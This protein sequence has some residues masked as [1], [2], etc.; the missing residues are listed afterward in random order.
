[1]TNILYYFYS[2]RSFQFATGAFLKR[3]AMEINCG[4]SL[5][6][7][8]CYWEAQY[9][10]GAAGRPDWPRPWLSSGLAGGAAGDTNGSRGG[11]ASAPVVN[12]SSSSK[13]V[14]NQ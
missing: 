8:V 3:F 14:A 11:A 2:R 12:R 13:P 5:L 1:M 9:A 10:I 6:L 4:A 7:A